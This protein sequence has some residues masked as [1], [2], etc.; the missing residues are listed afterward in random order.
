MKKGINE[1]EIDFYQGDLIEIVENNVQ[2]KIDYV[3]FS[4]ILSYF[5]EETGKNYL[6]RIKKKLN[7]GAL[8]IHRYYFHVNKNLITKGFRKVTGK[9]KSVILNEKTQIYLIDIFQK[10]EK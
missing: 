8:T 4:D 3:S 10:G 2:Q 6:Q 1:C 5:D 9:C 7:F